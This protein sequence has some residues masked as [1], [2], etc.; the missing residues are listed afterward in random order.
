MIIPMFNP[1]MVRLE[2][3]FQFT[4]LENEVQSLFADE[5]N[6][7]VAVGSCFSAYA[8]LKISFTWLKFANSAIDFAKDS[9]YRFSQLYRKVVVALYILFA[10]V[11]I[12]FSIARLFVVVTFVG[13]VLFLAILIL[14]M[15]SHRRFLN[16]IRNYTPVPSQV[17]RFDRMKFVFRRSKQ[18]TVASYLSIVLGW[19]LFV[20][21]F[22]TTNS[23]TAPGDLNY[24]YVARNFVHAARLVK[25][26]ADVWYVKHV[27]KTMERKQ[28]SDTLKTHSKTNL[29]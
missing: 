1:E 15:I 26:S 17:V 23:M 14:Y 24:S 6:A 4:G 28:A 9:Y 7:F 2:E 18:I 21:L 3:N 16:A 29:L 22:I 20:V 8:T 25:I 13:Q 27:L 12:I 11:T 10:L 5:S 19:A